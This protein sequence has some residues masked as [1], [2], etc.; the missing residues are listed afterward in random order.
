MSIIKSVTGLQIYSQKQ[1][2]KLYLLVFAAIIVI[3]SLY[4]ADIMVRK[5]ARDERQRVELWVN[6]IRQRETTLRE[7]ERLFEVIQNEEAK[8]V[9]LITQIYG[10]LNREDLS[11]A[12]LTI[13]TNVLL[14]N[15]TIPLI[16]T[17]EE[18]E[19]ITTINLDERFSHYTE[20]TGEL[21]D[22][23]SKYPPLTF[24]IYDGIRYIYY[25]DSKVFTELRDMMN[26]LIDTFIS[27]LVVNSANVPVIVVD[28]KGDQLIA[29]GNIQGVDFDNQ[30]EVH[31]LIRSMAG[32]SRYLSV[33]LP[34][35]GQC[36]VYYTSSFLLTQLRYFPIVQLLA[37]GILLFVAYVLF[38]TARK[39]EQNQVWVGMS[40]ETAHQLGTPLSSLIAWV[41]ILKMKGV[42]DET[43]NEIS[44]D[45]KRLENITER[46]SKIGATPKLEEDDV[47]GPVNEVVEYM[48]KRTSRNVSFQVAAPRE[49]VMVPHNGNLLGWVVENIIKNAIDAMKGRG[50]IYISIEDRTEEVIIDISDDGKGIPASQHKAI[51]NPGFTSKKTGWGLGLSLSKRIIEHYHGGK[52]FVKHSAINIGTTFRII[53]NKTNTK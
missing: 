26:D 36:Y 30:D 49:K 15:T 2:W 22:Y 40:K 13:Y 45:V 41:E 17:D 7:G 20:L 32:K 39:A 25:Q 29:H 9:E 38:S 44:K 37:V 42:D 16:L 28:G 27:D 8:R 33:V 43:M 6:A 52:L 31:K 21:A 3:F 19:V 48:K 14:S 53:L 12:D 51:F 50:R 10:R 4:Y 35:Y 5:I 11:H 46:F 1:K 18:G 23:F 24:P 47:V 34:N